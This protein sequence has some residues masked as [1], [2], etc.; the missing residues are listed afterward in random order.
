MSK[1]YRIT[2]EYR[3]HEGD[4]QPITLETCLVY[5]E[6]QSDFTYAP[7]L[8]VSG[9]DGT[10]MT[11]PGDFFMWRYENVQIPF[12]HY[13]S[14]I[15]VSGSNDAVISRMT[16]VAGDLGADIEEG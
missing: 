12:R 16:E 4:R 3:E 9:A 5:F 7:E 14:D 8:K 1:R 13:E 2:R 15:Y 10:T 6:T 11:I